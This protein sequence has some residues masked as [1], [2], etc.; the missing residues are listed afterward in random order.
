MDMTIP[1]ERLDRLAETAV[2]VGLNLARG[3][4]LVVTASLDA[5]PLVRRITEHAYRAGASLVTT[6]YAD[7]E[8]RLARFRHAPDEAFDV[9]AGW[10]AEGIAAAFR[11]GAAR[12]AIAGD[13]PALLSG[14]VNFIEAP[15][16]DAI[17]VL[18]RAG[19]QIVSNTYPHNWPYVLNFTRGPFTDLRVRQAANYAINRDDVVDLVGGLA[20]PEYAEVP[21]T[22]PYYGHPVE[23]SSTRRRPPP[24]SR[25]RTASRARS[26]WRSP[27]RA[28]ARCSPCR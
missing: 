9:A 20:T 17:P 3:Q 6:F 28:R 11:G 27:P 13:D 10:L 2:R 1:D 5:V 4:E 24:C 7:D 12:L 22:M 23:M 14:Q 15:A 8:S 25:R 16:P 21:P 18:K 19:M 26:R